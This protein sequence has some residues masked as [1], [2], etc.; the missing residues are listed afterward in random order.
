MGMVLL[1]SLLLALAIGTFAVQIWAR[2]VPPPELGTEKGRLRPCPER[3]NCV[4][5]RRDGT[6]DGLEPLPLPAGLTVEEAVERLERIIESMP[7]ARVTERRGP[8]LAAEY[9]SRIFRFPDDV[10][11]LVDEEAGCVHFR[12]ASRLGY[13]DRGVNQS[14]IEEIRRRW[15][16]TRAQEL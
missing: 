9:R 14:R 10:E 15:N 8:Y 1:F 16:A 2:T 11:L 3:P 6:G 13:Y 12:S 5:S 7:R 4:E